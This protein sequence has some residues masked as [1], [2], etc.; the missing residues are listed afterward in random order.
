MSAEGG[1]GTR[2]LGLALAGLILG[3]ASAGMREGL[4]VNQ[5]PE[6][7]RPDYT[8]FSHRCSRCHPLARALNSG[9][10]QDAVWARYVARMRRQ[11][12]SGISREDASQ[13]LRFL[14]Y[15]SLE[16]QRKKHERQAEAVFS[17]PAAA[18]RP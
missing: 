2:A 17:P 3:C 15:Y 1:W 7:V 13:I 12:G 16:Q 14:H 10:D 8:L 11:P 6:E 4:D 18:D 9:I 5:L